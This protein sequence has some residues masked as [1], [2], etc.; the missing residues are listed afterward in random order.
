MYLKGSRGIFVVRSTG[1]AEWRSCSMPERLSWEDLVDVV[2]GVIDD[3]V[4]ENEERVLMDG[5][6]DLIDEGDEPWGVRGRPIVVQDEERAFMFGPP[7][8]DD[9]WSD[10]GYEDVIAID[11]FSLV[12]NV[13]VLVNYGR[14]GNLLRARIGTVIICHYANIT[15]T[16]K[17][18][19][20][21]QGHYAYQVCV[22]RDNDAC[23][24]VAVCVK[25]GR[26]GVYWERAAAH[27]LDVK[28]HVT[29]DTWGML[30]DPQFGS[31]FSCYAFPSM[32]DVREAERMMARGAVFGNTMAEIERAIE[33]FGEGYDV[34]EA[35]QCCVG[36][37]S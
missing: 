2:R 12:Q 14:A 4:V 31:D 34:Y 20:V 6:V 30:F 3:E 33:M 7:W 19:H 1:R 9:D 16:Y 37:R 29:L 15:V 24:A 32:E 28:P 35:L 8:A 13:I 36:E 17:C 27:I 11:L 23:A 22:Y 10:A 25:P 21:M 18:S 26:D 5:V